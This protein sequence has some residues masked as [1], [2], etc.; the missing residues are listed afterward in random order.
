MKILVTIDREYSTSDQTNP[1]DLCNQG[2]LTLAHAQCAGGT[3]TLM[4]MEIEGP[5]RFMTVECL[6][7]HFKSLESETSLIQGLRQIMIGTSDEVK[8][9]N[10]KLLRQQSQ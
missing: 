1:L 2:Q 7:C 8:L 6:L 10:V 4:E 5:D 3:I 9:I